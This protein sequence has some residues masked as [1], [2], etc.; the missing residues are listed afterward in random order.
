MDGLIESQGLRQVQD[1]GQI[2]GWVAE[3]ISANPKMVDEYKAGKDKALNAMV[4]QVMKKSQGKANPRPL[5]RR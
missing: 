1:T 4:G 5:H 2:D 3:V